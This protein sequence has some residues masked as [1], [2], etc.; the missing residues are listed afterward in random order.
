MDWWVWAGPA[1]GVLIGSLIAGGAEA[2]RAPRRGVRRLSGTAAIAVLGG[3]T[4]PVVVISVRLLAG[5]RP[6]S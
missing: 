1:L 3:A 5:G 6:S 4:L 2:R